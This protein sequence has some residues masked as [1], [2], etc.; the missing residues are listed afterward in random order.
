MSPGAAGR[1]VLR[2]LIPLAIAVALAVSLDRL[3]PGPGA[4]DLA[5]RLGRLL[6]LLLVYAGAYLLLVR[7]FSRGLGLRQMLMQFRL[8]GAPPRR[9][10]GADVT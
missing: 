8:P 10:G 3:V 1:L 6:L 7:P 5:L 9:N 4:R 2:T